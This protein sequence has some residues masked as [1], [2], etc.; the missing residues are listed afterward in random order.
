ME[1][2]ARQ[3]GATDDDWRLVA[4]L[5][6]GDEGAFAALVERYQLP[7]LRLALAYVPDQ[8][9][10]EDVV[11]DTWLGVLNGLERFEGRS[12]LKTWIFRILTN[13]AKTRGQRERRS[14]PF[15]TLPEASLEGEGDP[16]VAANRFAPA[17]PGRAGGHW[18]AFPEAWDARPEARFAAAETLGHVR[19][20]I[21]GLP[22][23]QRAVIELRDVQGWSAAEA[24]EA[25]GL[26]EAN[27][28][29]LLHR[30][31]AKVRRALEQYL[32]EG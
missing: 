26:S 16:A 22:Q 24:R 15:S 14:L 28:R 29:V 12:S 17:S 9:A 1:R 4:A 20:A 18:L 31:R 21:D 25:L 30:A 5:R 6:R 23:A 13:R 7:L 3:T 19:Q 2:G 27:Q 10:A 8:A 32:G 11:G